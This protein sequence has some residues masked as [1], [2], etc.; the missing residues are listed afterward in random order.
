MGN[1]IIQLKIRA[2]DQNIFEFIKLG[3]KKIE[4]RAAIDRYKKITKGDKVLFVCGKEKFEKEV[5]TVEFFK[6]I[7]GLVKK[8]KLNQINPACKT[9]KELE[10]MYYSFPNYKE[11]IKKFGIIAFELK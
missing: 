5:K 9:V 11:K 2:V 1:K 8:Y 10:D 6:T 3:K 4:T 7:K